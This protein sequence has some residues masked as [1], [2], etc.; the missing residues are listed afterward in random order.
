M[1]DSAISGK[2][3]ERGGMRLKNAP[4]HRTI[5]PLMVP[6][7]P[8]ASAKA[9]ADAIKLA[10]A[11]SGITSPVGRGRRAA[12]GEGLRS[13]VRPEPLTRFAAQNRPLPMG[14]VNQVRG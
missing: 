7:W 8:C 13:L 4:D 2:F 12:P 5:P 9:S 11:A 14:E 10:G 3:S 6:A 1:L